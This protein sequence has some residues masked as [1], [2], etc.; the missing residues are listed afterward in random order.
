MMGNR[1][2]AKDDYNPQGLWGIRVGNIILRKRFNTSPEAW[3]W[4]IWNYKGREGWKLTTKKGP[5]E[6]TSR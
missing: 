2:A 4:A 6:S 3:D 1:H 5:L